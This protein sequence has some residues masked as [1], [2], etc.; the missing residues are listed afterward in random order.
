MIQ[1]IGIQKIDRSIIVLPGKLIEQMLDGYLFY[2]QNNQ[3]KMVYPA[4]RLG[5]GP[6]LELHS[7][8]QK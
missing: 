8:A 3:I 2:N 5:G 7:Y 6:S 4:W 1:S